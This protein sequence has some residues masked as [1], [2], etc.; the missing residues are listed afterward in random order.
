MCGVER[1]ELLPEGDDLD[2]E[3]ALPSEHRHEAAKDDPDDAEHG[4]GPF[5]ATA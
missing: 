5:P 4:A 3:C 1:H 2:R